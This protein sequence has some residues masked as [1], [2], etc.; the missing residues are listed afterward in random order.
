M[1]AFP[2]TDM[3]TWRM[4]HN[5]VESPLWFSAPVPG[6]G[7]GD[8]GNSYYSRLLKSFE[9]CYLFVSPGPWHLVDMQSVEIVPLFW[10]CLRYLSN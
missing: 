4:D 5:V 10:L 9:V 6:R 8:L 3:R 2:P 7:R 1:W